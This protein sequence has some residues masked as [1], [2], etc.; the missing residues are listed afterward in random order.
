MSERP[1]AIGIDFGGTSVKAGVVRGCEIIDHAP[2]IATQDFGTPQ[3]LIS[4]II[5]SIEDLRVRHP[6]VRAV[7][8]GMPGF[9]DFK[10]GLVLNLTNVRGWQDIPLKTILED[11][12]KLPVVAENDAN[13]MAFAEWKVG[14]G[15]GYSHLVCISLGTGVG[16]GVIVNGQMVRGAKYAAGEIGQ[17]SIDYQGRQGHYGNLGA[18]EDYIGNGEIAHDAQISYKAA[19]VTKDIEDCTPAALAEAARHGDEIALGQWKLIGRMLATAAMNT[20]WLLNPEAIV[21][22]GGVARAGD[23][24]FIPFRE[25]LLRQLSTPFKESLAILPAAFGHEAGTVGAAALA[26]EEAGF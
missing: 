17:T 6:D 22:G 3:D 15:R 12:L 11:K 23:L 7:G 25:H 24:L 10:K 19:G 21:I 8:I 2:P 13:C 1:L 16:G 26:L 14:A 4:T 5:R 9:V 18:L 20:C